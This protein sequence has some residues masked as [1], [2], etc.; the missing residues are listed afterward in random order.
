MSGRE[1]RLYNQY[2]EYEK[3]FIE[4]NQMLGELNQHK[5]IELYNKIQEHNILGDKELELA[6]FNYYELHNKNLI[7]ELILYDFIILENIFTRGSETEVSFRLALNLSL[8]ISSTRD[9]ISS[10][11]GTAN[12]VY[13]IRSKIIHGTEWGKYMR[14][15][16]IPALLGLD[17]NVNDR[18]LA[19]AVHNKLL[20]YINKSLK[21]IIH[22]KIE[23]FTQ[24]NSHEIMSDFT[25]LYFLINS[26]IFQDEEEE[27]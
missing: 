4:I 25:G 22:L 16:E 2:K 21:R 7:S 1:L 9:E 11:F 13:N 5:G 14:K 6:L 15:K 23:K 26:P 3:R 8:F 17:P 10:I 18:I 12:K 27:Y 19:R 24:N 20:S